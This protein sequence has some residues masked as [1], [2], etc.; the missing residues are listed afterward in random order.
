MSK[1][2]WRWSGE[3]RLG[4]HGLLIRLTNPQGLLG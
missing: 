1:S 3:G 4:M 2:A